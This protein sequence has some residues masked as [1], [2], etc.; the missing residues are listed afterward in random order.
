MASFDQNP[1]PMEEAVFGICPTKFF[2][3]VIKICEDYTADAMDAL[4]EE[5]KKDMNQK[6]QE[7]YHSLYDKYMNKLHGTFDYN[8]D[9]AEMYSVRNIF[10]VPSKAYPAWCAKQAGDDAAAMDTVTEESLGA[11][12]KVTREEE[13]ELDLKLK[14]ARRA[15]RLGKREKAMNTEQLAKRKKLNS[16]LKTGVTSIIDASRRC[17]QKRGC[18]PLAE[19]VSWLKG[20]D[21]ELSELTGRAQALLDQVEAGVGADGQSSTAPTPRAAHKGAKRAIATQSVDD[22]NK[23]TGRLAS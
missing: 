23:L 16:A 1:Y 5:L 20:R 11:T 17:A 9:K 19:K 15:V 13:E 10:H 14:E 12:E 22:V 8:M 7:T 3:G 21:A 4:E 6:E 2:D 18:A